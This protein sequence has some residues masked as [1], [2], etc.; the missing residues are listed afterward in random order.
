MPG[1]KAKALGIITLDDL[2]RQSPHLVLGADLEFLVR[3]E[4]QAVRQAY[5]FEFADTRRFAPSLMYNALASGDADVISAFSSDG[6]VAADNLVVLTDPRRALPGYDAVLL[7]SRRSADNS[8]F[9][10][11]IRPMVGRIGVDQMRQANYAVDRT[12]GK[13]SPE[14]AARALGCATGLGPCLQ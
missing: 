4:W 11:A 12:D 7:V 1:E 6:R 3:P 8:R 10:A 13:Q 2:A 9:L 5:R 14:A